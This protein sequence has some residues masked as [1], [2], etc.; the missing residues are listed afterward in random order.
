[1]DSLRGIPEEHKLETFSMPSTG[2]HFWSPP[3][4]Y[5]VDPSAHFRSR[6][7]KTTRWFL[8]TSLTRP[9]NTLPSQHLAKAH[10]RLKQSNKPKTPR[11]LQHQKQNQIFKAAN[12]KLSLLCCLKQSFRYSFCVPK[13]SFA[14][15]FKTAIDKNKNWLQLLTHLRVLMEGRTFSLKMIGWLGFMA[16]Q[17]MKTI[18]HTHKHIYIYI[19]VK[20]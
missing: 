19:F 12:K 9:T 16:Y 14:F 15:A 11:V 17:P 13:K 5:Y 6:Y 3:K 8:N 4:F 20:K 1:M 2:H 10:F 7:A 18:E